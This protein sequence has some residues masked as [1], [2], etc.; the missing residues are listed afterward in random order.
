MARHYPPPPFGNAS[1]PTG[2]YLRVDGREVLIKVPA[3][4]GPLLALTLQT[5]DR[6]LRRAAA[7]STQ[8]LALPVVLPELIRDEILQSLDPANTATSPTWMRRGYSV[9]Q[10]AALLGITCSGV[11]KRLRNGHLRSAQLADRNRTYVVDADQVDAE[12][13]RKAVGNG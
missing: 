4:C 2:D 10:T 6:A 11:R 5:G 1:H 12:V 9:E 13:S 8:G 7:A 3:E